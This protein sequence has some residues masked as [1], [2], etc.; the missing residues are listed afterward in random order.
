M[1]RL[2]IFNA[3][4]EIKAASLNYNFS[5]LYNY[6]SAIATDSSLIASLS[7]STTLADLVADSL[8][9]DPTFINTIA[10]E[11][12]SM[13]GFYESLVNQFNL[14]AS[15]F[16]L[17]VNTMEEDNEFLANLAEE[18][19]GSTNFV[20]NIS[21]SL[22][23]DTRGV[24]TRT[25]ISGYNQ[26]AG[27]TISYLATD[28]GTVRTKKS[29]ATSVAAFDYS[30]NVIY[31]IEGD[32][33]VIDVN[34]DGH[35]Y[36][37]Y[38]YD[39]EADYNTYHSAMKDN[40]LAGP[41]GTVGEIYKTIQF[42]DTATCIDKTNGLPNRTTGRIYEYEYLTW[43]EDTALPVG[44]EK[45]YTV[46]FRVLSTSASERFTFKTYNVNLSDNGF[47]TNVAHAIAVNDNLT[48]E[49]AEKVVENPSF[50]TE[51]S[52]NLQK[53]RIS[54]ETETIGAG[55][56]S[57][58]YYDAVMNMYKTDAFVLD[59]YTTSYQLTPR[60]SEDASG[61][62]AICTNGW[63]I[64]E[65]VAYPY[66]NT[67]GASVEITNLGIDVSGGC[68]LDLASS[69]SIGIGNAVATNQATSNRVAYVRAI[70]GERLYLANENNSLSAA[71]AWSNLGWT[72]P[73]SGNYLRLLDTLDSDTSF[74]IKIYRDSAFSELSY[75]S[76][77]NMY[78]LD[79]VRQFNYRSNVSGKLFLELKNNLGSGL[80]NPNKF[81]ID[82]FG[83]R[84]LDSASDFIFA[85]NHGH[86]Y[87]ESIPIDGINTIFYTTYDFK[88]NSTQVI[89]QHYP[90][91]LG[92][93]YTEIATSG[94]YGN[95][96]EFAIKPSG[97][98][99]AIINYVGGPN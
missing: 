5:F 97:D 68:Y 74:D 24:N 31:D 59:D 98:E 88:L 42:V 66:L 89:Q 56:T 13:S 6:L 61:N 48:H 9:E 50:V 85:S 30:T 7:N 71:T 73:T 45:I 44:V 78:Y 58:N 80:G 14:S 41:E 23:D 92:S 91:Q 34:P 60:L 26:T 8:N 72:S 53:I 21:D 28:S 75:E 87:N 10:L 95:A 70:A 2:F 47:V 11:L 3:N 90:L 94:S 96:I 46:S 64:G 57:G 1:D 38:R 40:Y 37:V 52:Q 82:I 36:K 83:Y 54:I 81:K 12:S 25:D 29:D 55:S 17:L 32:F 51:L 35:T 18:L 4:N 63:I 49:I 62:L 15:F 79:D 39:T 43:T 84:L 27:G 77:G 33:F 76:T 93:D 16:T 99:W 19:N 69:P 65:V 22:A 20:N 86:V 67:S